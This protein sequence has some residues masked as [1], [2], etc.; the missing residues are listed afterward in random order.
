MAYLIATLTLG[1]LFSE[2]PMSTATKPTTR[3]PNH[4]L[5]LMN[6]HAAGIDV[7]ATFHMV[8]VPPNAQNVVEVRSFGSCTPDLEALAAWL[9]QHGVTT[10]AMES[11]GVYW[12]ALYDLLE[13]KGFE[14][15]LV[16]PRQIQRAPGRPKTDKQDAQWIRRLHSLG[17][18]RTPS[19]QT[20]GS[21]CYV[22]SC[23][24]VP[25]S[26][27]TPAITSSICRRRWSK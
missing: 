19:A 21:A 22:V 3:R 10:V 17:L 15:L 9:T 24:S 4:D 1:L 2:D 18:L 5:E 7:S 6:P 23:V 25:T 20:R 13:S 11:T 26:S 12:I 16:D 27:V 8:A 14:V